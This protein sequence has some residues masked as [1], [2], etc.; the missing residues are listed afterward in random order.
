MVEGASHSLSDLC[1]TI[2]AAIILADEEGLTAAAALLEQARYAAHC[3][4]AS[5]ANLP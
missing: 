2:D 3:P 4:E 1:A 5:S